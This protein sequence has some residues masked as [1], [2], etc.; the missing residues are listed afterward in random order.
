MNDSGMVRFRWVG[1]W[2][3]LALSCGRTA[4]RGPHAASAGSPSAVG[5]T[6]SSGGTASGA[7]A[8]SGQASEGGA[9]DCPVTPA[10]GQWV[11]RGP[12]PY[13][14]ELSSDGSHLSGRGCLGDL[15]S[16]GDPILCSPLA[17]QADRGRRVAFVWDSTSAGGYVVKM[18]LTLAPDRTAMAGTVWTSLGSSDDGRDIVLV[19]HPVEPVP[20]ATACSGGE[21][22]GECFLHPLRSDRIDEPRV[23]ELGQGNLLLLWRN[24]RGV[25]ARLAS[26]RFDAATGAWQEAEFLDDGT[27]PVEAAILTGGPEG[28]AMVAY[29]QH[30]VILTRAYD[31]TLSAWSEHYAVAAGNDPSAIAHPLSL[32]VYEGGSATLVTSVQDQEG[33][34]G[35]SIHEFAA[36]AR[37]WEPSHL[38][39]SSIGAPTHQWAAA[40][41]QARNALVLWAREG[42]IE[43]PDELW[44]SSRT[45]GGPWSEAARF[46]SSEAQILRP[47][48]AVGTN[49]SA[50]VTWQEFLVRIASS[51]YSFQT[52]DWS[53]PLLVTS[54][55]DVDNRA[56]AFSEA[57]AAVAYFYRNTALSADAEQKSEL[58]NGVWGPAQTTSAAEAS[59]QSYSVALTAGDLQVTPM[60]GRAGQ[61]ALPA[62]SR[63]RCEGY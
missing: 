33:R 29:R 10:A 15:P 4:D 30:N 22:S 61:S 8:S 42:S 35:V 31:P 54:G 27:A 28:W 17:L 26:A 6:S 23:I 43:E 34:S 52:A 9:S 62:L 41:D 25:G 7:E 24:Q 12:D 39:D 20:P 45:A 46:Y 19:R 63:P 1:C 21:P 38:I 59:G 55:Q 49:G 37:R 3:L 47:A 40:S 32:F 2:A 5:G 16:Q 13:G 58:H 44:F 51:S 48:V 50:I 36:G 11:A 53:E 57:G 56:V 18:D 60:S 14:F